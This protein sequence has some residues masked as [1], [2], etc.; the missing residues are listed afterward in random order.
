MNA[1]NER[2]AQAGTRVY[3][4]EGNVAQVVEQSRHGERSTGDSVQD[5]AQTR[6]TDELGTCGHDI[7]GAVREARAALEGPAFN[8]MTVGHTSKH[9]QAALEP[10]EHEIVTRVLSDLGFTENGPQQ[11]TEVLRNAVVDY[12]RLDILAEQFW[13]FARDS[14]GPLTK[15]GKTRSVV[16]H[17]RSTVAQKDAL[18]AKFGYARK[19]KPVTIHDYLKQRE[20]SV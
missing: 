7:A 18:G 5:S 12:A 13:T 3:T 20:P 15:K 16:T 1:E 17:W 19:A 11:P 14:G 9:L 8:A 10:L 4:A 6:A 2:P